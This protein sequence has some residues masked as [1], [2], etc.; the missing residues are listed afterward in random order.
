MREKRP[1]FARKLQLWGAPIVGGH[2]LVAVWH[3]MLMIKVQPNFPRLAVPFL[4]L[5]NLLPIAGVIAVAK[6]YRKLGGILI[7][8]PLGIALVV[9]TYA[10]FLSPGT[11]NVFHM[12]PGDLRLPF[13]AS[14]SLL[15]LLE[16]LGCW[17]GLRIL[18][19]PTDTA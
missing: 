1:D 7:I 2:F 3:L 10:H 12:P 18:F 9:G 13:Q 17:I 14:A 15:A 11:D 19:Q 8:V 16:G 6:E 5:V 4:I